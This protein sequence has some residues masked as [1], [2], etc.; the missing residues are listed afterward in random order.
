M[1]GFV[2]TDPLLIRLPVYEMVDLV[3][4]AAHLHVQASLLNQFIG[5]LDRLLIAELDEV[6]G[7]APLELQH[8]L[9]LCI[10]G[11]HLDR[12]KR[13]HQV[14]R[15]AHGRVL[16][17]FALDRLGGLRPIHERNIIDLFQDMAIHKVEHLI[18]RA[19]PPLFRQA[20]L[21]CLIL[22]WQ[23]ALGSDI[24]IRQNW[25]VALLFKFD[26]PVEHVIPFNDVVKFDLNL[27]RYISAVHS[28]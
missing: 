8:P 19:D 11:L 22:L 21:H 28:Q 4:G 3:V 17:P 24:L 10:L 16:R 12:V 18:E 2:S 5:S 26:H 25:V 13:R 20:A 23:D 27:R 7:L 1:R 9:L 6:S 14:E 15:R